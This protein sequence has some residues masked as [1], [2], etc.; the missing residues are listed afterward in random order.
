V[1]VHRSRLMRK[2]KAHSLLALSQMM[3]KLQLV[4]QQPH[5]C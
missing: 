2:M 1:K 5:H 3:E 4:P